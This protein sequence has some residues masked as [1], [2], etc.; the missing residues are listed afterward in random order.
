MQLLATNEYLAL[1][2]ELSLI[3]GVIISVAFY[4]QYRKYNQQIEREEMIDNFLKH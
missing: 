1:S 2:N 4:F 3:A